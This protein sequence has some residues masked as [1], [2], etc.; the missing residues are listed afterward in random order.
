MITE[1]TRNQLLE[2]ALAW[3]KPARSF[4]LPRRTDD[5]YLSQVRH[6]QLRVRMEST[7]RCPERIPARQTQ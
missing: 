5:W 4:A 3:G 6:E 2:R 7:R 1:T